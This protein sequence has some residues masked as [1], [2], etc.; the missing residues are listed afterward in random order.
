LS[1]AAQAHTSLTLQGERQTRILRLV[2]IRA[3]FRAPG[4]E[5]HGMGFSTALV[6][7][8][9][10]VLAAGLSPVEVAVHPAFG[11]WFRPGLP[12]ALSLA[13]KGTSLPF[14]GKLT[15][16]IGGC[17]FSHR[18]RV[19]PGASASCELVVP[20]WVASAAAR[21]SVAAPDGRVISERVVELPLTKL[22]EGKR[23]AAVV[24]DEHQ[25][26]EPL[27]GDG[28]VA[29]DA[30]PLP[31]SAC[32]Y[33]VLDAL[34]VRGDGGSL[35]PG[36]GAVAW[37]RGGGQVVFVVDPGG[38]VA[39][40]SLLASLG[41]ESGE[42]SGLLARLSRRPGVARGEGWAAWPVGLGRA[43]VVLSSVARPPLFDGLL[44]PR[45]A[46]ALANER[47]YAAFPRP[48]WPRAVRWRLVVAP[49]ALMLLAV[50]VAGAAARRRRARGAA[51]AIGGLLAAAIVVLLFL[52]QGSALARIARVVEQGG[53]FA[54]ATDIMCL[55]GLGRSRVE[56][57]F[58][59]V[60]AVLPLGFSPGSTGA[61]ELERISGDSWILRAE[62]EGGDRRCFVVVGRVA[63]AER[64][65]ADH[66]LIVRQGRFVDEAGRERSL[67]ELLPQETLLRALVDWQ[68]RR[69]RP[70][71]T[72]QVTWSE[73]GWKR[74]E[75]E[76][77]GLVASLR[78]PALWWTW[79]RPEDQR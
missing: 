40:G 28:W 60:E 8:W 14:E 34:V 45:R 20:A 37:A 35:P 49:V 27:L 11:G 39:E 15:L 48:R 42:V 36:R 61:G 30:E 66:R 31:A 9:Q 47:L 17:R 74:A 63:A 79:R 6:L 58:R 57:V 55:D 4:R 3:R 59:G 52:P 77:Q 70:G 10:A 25:W 19:P 38:V 21:L 22:D 1:P 46:E 65:P 53:N 62:V 26:A 43:A 69:L 78:G 64:S 13:V 75:V 16:E 54:R 12:A 67:A 41:A 50:L 5:D 56:M 18:V 44:L 51:L 73:A 7:A 2:A 71:A 24:G 32:G 76:G 68:V 33:L 23:L 72:Y 29:V